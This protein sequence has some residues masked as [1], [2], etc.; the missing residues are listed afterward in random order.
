MWATVLG[1]P[2]GCAD[3]GWDQQLAMRNC[4]IVISKEEAFDV[5]TFVEL[6]TEVAGKGVFTSLTPKDL[7]LG[8]LRM[9]GR[10]RK[11]A[12]LTGAKVED[13]DVF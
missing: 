7:I 13:L 9:K 10:D 2:Y 5:L 12:C 6:T 11:I 8:P 4:G 1:F 3:F